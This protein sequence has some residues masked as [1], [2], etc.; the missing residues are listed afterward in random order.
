MIGVQRSSVLVIHDPETRQKAGEV[1]LAGRAGNPRPFFRVTAPEL[2]A[3]DYDTL[4]RV[5][6]T[7]WQVVAA[8][9]LQRRVLPAGQF[10]GDFTVDHDERYCVV[11]RPFSRDVV[12]VEME[13]FK[14]KLRA[15]VAGQPL[16]AVQ[17]DERVVARDWKTGALL[18][19]KL[20]RETG[21][22]PD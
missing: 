1:T 19:A 4:L 6:T 9:C 15:T 21:G 10:V 22:P 16:E 2:W 18:T 8:R 5:Q 17:V 14:R 12:V 20:R 11:P 3:I 7:D 13:T